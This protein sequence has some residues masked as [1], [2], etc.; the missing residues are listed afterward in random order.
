MGRENTTAVFCI[1]E[2]S[3]A[4][5]AAA[6]AE[7]AAA[8]HWSDARRSF[9]G[10]EVRLQRVTAERLESLVKEAWPAQAP[11]RLVSARLDQPH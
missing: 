1:T 7:H 4:V 5:V 9:L 10:L 11:R 8:V 2:D 6:H 3:A